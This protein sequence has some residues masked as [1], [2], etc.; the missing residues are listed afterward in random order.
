MEKNATVYTV[1]IGFYKYMF[2]DKESALKVFDVLVSSKCV[3]LKS[4]G[5]DSKYS[6]P[7]KHP[8]INLKASILNLYNC[9]EEARV[10]KENEDKLIKG[11]IM[12]DKRKA[13]KVVVKKKK[14]TKI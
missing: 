8:V 2:P 14:E 11:G 4:E 10:S 13:P 7:G 5:Y 3:E 9:A 1:E 12:K 6:Y